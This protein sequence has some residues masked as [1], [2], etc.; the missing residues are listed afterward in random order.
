MEE[1]SRRAAICASI[2]EAVF[3]S[4]INTMM[5]IGSRTRLQEEQVIIAKEAALK[6]ITASISA[7]ANAAFARRDVVLSQIRLMPNLRSRARTAPFHGQNLMGPNPEEF[8]HTVL[9]LKDDHVLHGGLTDHFEVDKPASSRRSDVW[10]R[11]GPASKS[12]KES[13]KPAK[14]SFR[15]KEESSRERESTRHPDHQRQQNSR[16]SRGARQ[17]GRGRGSGRGSRGSTH[18]SRR[19]SYAGGSAS[20]GLQPI[21]EESSRRGPCVP[22]VA[23]RSQVEMDGS[24]STTNATSCIVW[25]QEQPPR[26]S[27]GGG[28]FTVEG[29]SGDGGQAIFSRI[30]QSAVPGAQENWRYAPGYRLITAQPSSRHSPFQNGDTS[31]RQICDPSGGMGC[32]SRY[33]GCLSPR[34]YVESCEQIPAVQSQPPCIPI[35]M[36]SLRLSNFSSGVHQVAAASY[37]SSAAKRDPTACVF[38]RL[39]HSSVVTGTGSIACQFSHQGSPAPGLDHQFRQVRT[40]AQPNLRLHW[41]AVRHAHTPWRP[42]PR[43]ESKS[44]TRWIIGGLGLWSQ[45][46]TF[47]D[48]WGS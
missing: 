1:F 32:V 41:H 11:L 47:T 38:G 40:P 37:G 6:V 35:H 14:Q 45:P 29:S 43:C 4:L 30:L 24:S 13:S 26:P 3:G 46:G 17:R 5:P 31:I 19:W 12:S 20:G 2:S 33:S 23:G 42:Y 21:L 15:G 16:S 48:S 28:Q 8:D 39:A 27:T 7:S 10:S 44:A 25:H 34:S 18:S 36:S 9:K 22:D